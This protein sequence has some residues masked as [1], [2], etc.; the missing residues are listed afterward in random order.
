M[1]QTIKTG[2]LKDKFGKKANL[3]L[4]LAQVVQK[5]INPDYR[6][7]HSQGLN[8]ILNKSFEKL[9]NC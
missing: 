4:D 1:F 8:E 6:L 9:F 7:D 3:V 2:R 5:P